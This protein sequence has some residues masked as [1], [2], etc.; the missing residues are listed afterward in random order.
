MTRKLSNDN[1]EIAITLRRYARTISQC[2]QNVVT[3]HFEIGEA[4]EDAKACLLENEGYGTFGAWIDKNFAMSERTATRYRD[5]YKFGEWFQRRFDPEEKPLSHYQITMTAVGYLAQMVTP[6]VQGHYGWMP[7]TD[8][9]ARVLAVMVAVQET[10]A[11]DNALGLTTLKEMI[12]LME[13]LP[14]ADLPAVPPPLAV[15]TPEEEE[16]AANERAANE[17]EYE[18]ERKR[19]ADEAAERDAYDAVPEYDFGDEINAQVKQIRDQDREAMAKWEAGREAREAEAAAKPEEDESTVA[20]RACVSMLA[21]KTQL[22]T[23]WDDALA[24]IPAGTLRQV[25]TSLEA[26]C[27]KRET[28][29]KVQAAADRAAKKSKVVRFPVVKS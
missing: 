10:L 7:E 22:V 17:A 6:F 2:R 25:I 5:Q 23:Q 1:S 21:N 12:A 18:A 28:A 4:L 8:P 13:K 24:E 11:D 29:A 26:V 3:E 9:S 15:P 27:D 16:A 20:I 19:W 14:E